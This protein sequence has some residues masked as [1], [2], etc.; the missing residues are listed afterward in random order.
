MK[1]IVMFY[2]LLMSTCLSWAQHNNPVENDQKMINWMKANRSPVTGMPLSFQPFGTWHDVYSEMGEK[3]SSTSIIERM[4][5]NR[6]ISIYDAAL[7]QI[8]L[9][10]TGDPKD[11]DM[12]YI[13][14]NNY[15]KGSLD[16]LFNIRSGSGG[17]PFVY[18]P[19]HPNAV[20]SDPLEMGKRGFIFRIMNANGKYFATD[21][22]DGKTNY[23]DFPNGSRI[24]W[25]DWKPIAGENAWVVMAALHHLKEKPE[26]NVSSS[27]ELK[28]SQE[29]SRAAFY[30]QAEN[31]GIRMAP[32]GTYYQGLNISPYST[33]LQI[34]QAL[35]DKTVGLEYEVRVSKEV[36]Q[37]LGGIDYPSFYTWY[38]N[39]ISTENNLSWYA[40]FRMLYQVTGQSQYLQ[41]M[42]RIENYF[43]SMWDP[44]QKVFYHGA[45]YHT[46]TKMWIS[47]KKLFAVDV[48]NW[49]IIVL[50]PQKIDEWFGEG[51]AYAIWRSTKDFS[52]VYGSSGLKGV[53]FTKGSDQISIE[54]TAG[55]ILAT[56]KLARYYESTHPDWSK[57]V[58][59]DMKSMRLGVDEYYFNVRPNGAAYSYSSVRQWIPFGWFSHRIP[60]LSLASTAWIVL[61]DKH[62]N[63]FEL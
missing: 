5:V 19:S 21:P 55:A 15:W 41:A 6:G 57:E 44:K 10:S 25:E 39:E 23:K 40:A 27:V 30:L 49:S 50:G 43:K 24:H 52:G 20:L 48:Q 29:L 12:A 47:H 22:L 42:G 53:G 61:I 51:S 8:V 59:N 38:Y 13:P 14:I 2:I 56:D 60:V 34:T 54:W 37:R 26:E 3:F 4:I 18:D 63:P 1:L 31:G 9:S 36:S 58:N 7:W 35:D 62:I 32:L 45:H 17:Q 16:K 46:D 11:W 28:L 33:N